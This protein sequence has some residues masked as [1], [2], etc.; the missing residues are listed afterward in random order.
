MRT[1]AAASLGLAMMAGAASSASAGAKI[2]ID[3]FEAGAPSATITIPMW[4]VKGASKLL[5]KIAGKAM[6]EQVDI[7]QLIALAQDTEDK[8]RP[9]RD[10]GPSEQGARR[11]INR[12]RRAEA[13]AEVTSLTASSSWWRSVSEEVLKIIRTGAGRGSFGQLASIVCPACT[14]LRLRA[15]G[16]L[17]FT[18]SVERAAAIRVSSLVTTRR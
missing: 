12:R 4:A 16:G 1:I 3:V 8:R 13:H 7:D 14:E 2:K 15:G 10:R 6:K 9:A 5:P 11:H 17:H 18:T